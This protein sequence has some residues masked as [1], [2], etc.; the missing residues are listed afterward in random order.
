MGSGNLDL[1]KNDSIRLAI[2]SWQANL[3]NMR[4]WE[5][6]DQNSQK[7]YVDYLKKHI[8]FYNRLINKPELTESD[9]TAMFQDRIFLNLVS[10]R[11]RCPK[12][13]NELYI[14]ELPKLEYLLEQ[15]EK[16]LKL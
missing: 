1:I 7:D 10:Y 12:V 8:N 16:E 15:I 5:L 11:H 6:L 9:K 2:G 14:E 4:A 3:K 13:L